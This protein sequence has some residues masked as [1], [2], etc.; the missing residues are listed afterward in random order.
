M[1]HTASSWPFDVYRLEIGTLNCD[2]NTY[3]GV[4]RVAFG[5]SSVRVGAA[6]ICFWFD[7][8]LHPQ[9]LFLILLFFSFI[10]HIIIETI[11]Q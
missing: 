2:G 11:I 8:A 6:V 9:L 10:W 5:L 1:T 4:A 7:G 3:A